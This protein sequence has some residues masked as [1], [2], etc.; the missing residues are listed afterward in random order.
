MSIAEIMAEH[1]ILYESHNVTTEDGYI[2][3]MFRVRNPKAQM[4]KKSAAILVM[5]GFLDSTD[6]FC[7]NGRNNS[8]AFMLADAGYEVWLANTRGSKHSLGH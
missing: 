7:I 8:I 5:H 2:N 4:G 6:T 3:Q 1:N